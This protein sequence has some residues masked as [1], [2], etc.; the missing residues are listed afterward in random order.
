MSNSEDHN[1]SSDGEDQK[2]AYE[3]ILSHPSYFSSTMKVSLKWK[4]RF[5]FFASKKY[6][7]Y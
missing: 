4:L 3:S 7:A 6:H 1:D 2:K 5:N